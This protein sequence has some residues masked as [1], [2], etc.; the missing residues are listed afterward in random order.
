MRVGDVAQRVGQDDRATGTQ[1]AIGAVKRMVILR[2]EVIQH[3]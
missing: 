2:G 1:I 3:L